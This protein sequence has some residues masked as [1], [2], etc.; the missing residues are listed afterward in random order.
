MSLF[1][2]ERSNHGEMPLLTAPPTPALCLAKS[3]FAPGPAV[4]ETSVDEGAQSVSLGNVH[5][6]AKIS[7][8][9][10]TFDLPR[11][12]PLT[13]GTAATDGGGVG[14]GGQEDDQRDGQ[15]TVPSTGMLVAL[16]WGD[17]GK[18]KAPRGPPGGPGDD[19]DPD[20]DGGGGPN[21]RNDPARRASNANAMNIAWRS[22]ANSK[23]LNL[24][25]IPSVQTLREWKQHCI[26]AVAGSRR[27]VHAAQT[28]VS[29]AMISEVPK[30]NIKDSGG[31]MRLDMMIAACLFVELAKMKRH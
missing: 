8:H 22:Y 31:L 18:S 12:A 17:S 3:H 15:S 14:Q 16:A 5:F 6:N 2:P 1:K 9:P 19:G 28:W 30:G 29:E 13:A 23:G 4:E 27:D 11:R 7:S 21:D 20:G 26:R 25:D 10:N 24:F